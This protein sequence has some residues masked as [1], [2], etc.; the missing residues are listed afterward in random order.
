MNFIT[1][2]RKEMQEQWRTYRFLIVLA[3][4][5][6]FGLASPLL[7]KFTPE[8]LKAIPGVPAGLLDA[9]PAPTIADAVT[10]YIKNM[11]QFGILLALLMAM[12]MVVQEKERGTAAFFLTRPVSRETFVLAKFAALTVT[13]LASLAV[14]AIGCWYYTYVLFEP[15]AWGPFLALNGLM[16]VVF[17]VY[18]ALALLSST[19]AHSQGVAVGL[20]FVAL[21]A[22]G[23]IGALPVIGEY[24]PG[25]LFSWGASLMLGG[26]GTAWP[27]LGISLGTIV[28]ALLSAC[29]LFCRQ[30]I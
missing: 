23:G 5:A 21:L 30:E 28:V 8:M 18:M 4:L 3:V 29:L 24:F 13:F 12:G 26:T 16:L 22:V 2:F 10:Q 25:R 19:V 7:A 17:L 11:S 1:V 27:A 15:L 9:I 20:A 6:A 14:A